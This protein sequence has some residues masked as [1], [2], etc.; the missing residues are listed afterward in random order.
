MVPH[1][2]DGV[3]TTGVDTRVAA[4]VIPAVLILVALFMVLALRPALLEWVSEVV[5]NAGAHSTLVLDLTMG[6]AAAG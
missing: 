4:P 2:T 6:V 1:I 3:F 5:V